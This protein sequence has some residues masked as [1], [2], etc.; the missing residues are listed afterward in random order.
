MFCFFFKDPAP[1]EIYTDGHTLSLHDAL[2]SGKPWRL[3]RRGLLGW[4]LRF[5]VLPPRLPDPSGGAAMTCG[6]VGRSPVEAP[7][8][9]DPAG[10]RHDAPEPG[11]LMALGQR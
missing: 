1:P 4:N 6:S 7:G 8:G 3:A 9:S 11:S 10:V 5:T 2:P